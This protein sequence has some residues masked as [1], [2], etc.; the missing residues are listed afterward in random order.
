M[1]RPSVDENLLLSQA[2]FLTGVKS[3]LQVVVTQV[4]K[5][6]Q[7][8]LVVHGVKPHQTTC[9]GPKKNFLD[10]NIQN[11]NYQ[12]QMDQNNK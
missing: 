5:A 12:V 10:S 7:L 11:T 3:V 1:A 4:Q 2:M 9:K 8:F 6:H